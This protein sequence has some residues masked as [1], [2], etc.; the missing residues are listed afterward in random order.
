[1]SQQDV[2]LLLNNYEY[3]HLH[4]I[5]ELLPK[6]KEL[7]CMI[8][9]AKM[10]GFKDIFESLRQSLA[11]G[12]KARF[13]IG[14]D[15]C[16]TDPELLNQLLKL[17][18]KY[19]LDL[20]L[21]ASKF[22]FHPKIYALTHANGCTVLIGSANLTRGGLGDN[23]E[24]SAKVD[25]LSGVLFQ[26]VRSHID[27]LLKDGELVPATKRLIAE[28]ERRH[29]INKTQQLLAKRRTE[30]A[31][32]RAASLTTTD[33]TT[34]SEILQ[35]MRDDES[36]RGFD[37][38]RLNRSENRE[39]AAHK[40][41]EI[42]RLQHLN[43]GQFLVHYEELIGAFHSG[44]LHRGK[45]II[46]KNGE[47]FR[48]AVFAITQANHLT[49][50]DAYQLLQDHFDQIPRAGVN[51][52]TEILHAL[53]NK[54]YAIMNQNAVSGLQLAG[55]YEF[56]LHPTKKT[57]SSKDYGL[58]CQQADALCGELMLANFTELDAL[59]NYAYWRYDQDIDQGVEDEE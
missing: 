5:S 32:K 54:R 3:G 29:L 33:T 39:R 42:A 30:K 28:Y 57:V 58:F 38:N 23:Y 13:A 12:L 49:P 26:S 16:Q 7:D 34:L 53:D 31:F 11:K 18:K 44:G 46:A 19:D 55:I 4:A 35:E 14:L 20:Y 21:S 25:D 36:D 8:A 45:N 37:A 9:F 17:K 59:F 56:P 50:S 51:V 43:A 47:R 6:G 15:F 27:E 10:S 22:T 24:A 2:K 41:F 48:H 1:M 40:I 52:M